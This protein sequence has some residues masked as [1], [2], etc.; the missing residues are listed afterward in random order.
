MAGL[1]IR[2]LIMRADSRRI[3]VVAPGSL[4]EQ[5]R[6]ELFEKFGLQFSV[7]SSAAAGSTPTGNPFEDLDHLIVRLDQMARNEEIQEKLSL[8]WDLVIFD[9]AH[10]LSAHFYGNKVE[11]TGRF[12]L[13]EKLGLS[14]PAERLRIEVLTLMNGVSWPTA[15]VILHFFHP[16]DYP[17]LDF[18]ALWS[19]KSAVPQPYEFVF[20]QAYTRHCRKLSK[21]SGVSM[22]T[23]DRALWQFS[24]ENQG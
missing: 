15:S 12:Q 6:E 24:K 5:W 14:T 19:L 2:E 9:E 11:K 21:L 13:A 4:V 16:D 20:W 1:Y 3:L 17:I 10:K 18:R 8:P 23:V 22:R 7:F